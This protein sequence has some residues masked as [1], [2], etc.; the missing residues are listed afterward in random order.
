MSTTAWVEVFGL[1]MIEAGVADFHESDK[2]HDPQGD[3]TLR[4]GIHTLAP[5][6]PHRAGTLRLSRRRIGE[7]EAELLVRREQLGLAGQALHVEAAI[8]FRPEPLGRPLT[9]QY[10]TRQTVAEARD[11]V[12]LALEREG[13]WDGT[14]LHVGNRETTLDAPATINWLLFESV[15]RLPRRAGPPLAFT[16]ID[17]FDQPKPGQTLAWSRRVEVPAPG[18]GGETL[19]LDCFDQLG[20]GI[21]PWTYWVD[22]LGRTRFAV[23]GIEAYL[24]ENDTADHTGEDDQ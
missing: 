7:D 23:S 4:W 1:N 13:R 17:H 8:R 5:G 12:A 6:T 24:L 22:P 9:W 21:V 16:L 20:R 2:P 15:P 14:T 11:P 19:R 3:W 10:S 18:D